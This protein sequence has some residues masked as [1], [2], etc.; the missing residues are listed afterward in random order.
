MVCIHSGLEAG[1][2]RGIS[3]TFR[4]FW[5]SVAVIDM[6]VFP[7]QTIP[8]RANPADPATRFPLWLPFIAAL[9]I[10]MAVVVLNYRATPDAAL[11][12][13]RFGWEMGWIARSLAHGHGFSSP[14]FAVSGPTAMMPPLYPA[15][16]AAVFH[17]FGI[18]SVASAFVVLSLNSVFSSLICITVYFIAKHS[19]G[20]RLGYICAWAWAIH[21]FAIYFS[22]NRV[23]DYAL[24]GLLLSICLC[25]AQRLT[26]E[27]QWSAWL[28]FGM[29]YGLTALS[30]PAVLNVF[31]F[32][33]LYALY[34][35][36][37]KSGSTLR[38]GRAP[39]ALAGVIVIVLPWTIR[40][41]RAMHVLCPVRD[42]FWQEFWAGNTGDA[43]NPMP[44]WTHPASNP[45]EMRKYLASGEVA[46]IAQKRAMAVDMVRHHPGLFAT[47]SFRRVV[48]F[49]TGFWSLS[50]AYLHDE[51]FEVPNVFFCSALTL[52]MLMGLVRFLRGN[53][54]AALPYAIFVAIFPLIYYVTHPLMDYRQ[55]IEPEI[56]VLIVFA[57]F[58][59]KASEWQA[60]SEA[61]EL[62]PQLLTL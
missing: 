3:L 1:A 19:F 54:S 25:I 41:E 56:L 35:A 36:Y 26:A 21:P 59:S 27:H 60:E 40:C 48:Y 2:L 50:P 22:A 23:W 61:R 47:R 14:F 53:R 32:L 45:A 38:L 4:R 57:L 29:I 34:N 43:S 52:F 24:T 46:Y 51:P 58:P 44:G 15:L 33:L 55:P 39:I 11:H 18:Y 16:I 20:P 13:E 8:E 12:Y 49:W 30:N 17:L 6:K 7:G 10:R 31:P 5:P 37:N 28:G 62:E 42:N 9:A